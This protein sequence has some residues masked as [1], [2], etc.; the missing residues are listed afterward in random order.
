MRLCVRTGAEASGGKREETSRLIRVDGG[1]I[2]QSFLQQVSVGWSTAQRKAAQSE[3]RESGLACR[4]DTGPSR[5]RAVRRT[6]PL[7]SC[8]ALLRWGCSACCAPSAS[9]SFSLPP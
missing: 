5:Q 2:A 3:A 6:A 4:S 9:S 7:C 8:D 1:S